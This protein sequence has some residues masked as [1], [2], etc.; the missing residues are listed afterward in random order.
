[1]YNPPSWNDHSVSGT[2]QCEE[3][4][5]INQYNKIKDIKD[6]NKLYLYKNYKSNSG[7][8]LYD[9]HLNKTAFNSITA[10]IYNI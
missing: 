7:Q 9:A 8:G 10:S 5:Y 1:M 3:N 6:C 4:V 2:R